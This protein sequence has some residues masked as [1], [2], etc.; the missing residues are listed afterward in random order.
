MGSNKSEKSDIL[1][2]RIKT[3]KTPITDDKDDKRLYIRIFFK[4][5]PL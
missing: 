5:K 3:N 2:P 1:D 4:D